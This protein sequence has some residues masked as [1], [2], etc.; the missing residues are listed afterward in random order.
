MATS[1][2]T[3]QAVRAALHY[4]P[5]TGVFRWLGTQGPKSKNGGVAG[6]ICGHT[7]YR[8]IRVNGVGCLAHRLAWLYM[9]GEWPKHLIDHMNHERADNRWA[10]LREVT[11]RANVE[12]KRLSSWNADCG[13]L[14]VSTS[15]DGYKGAMP[16]KAA[17]THNG[18]HIFIGRFATPQEAAAAYLGAKRMVHRG[19]IPPATLADTSM[20]P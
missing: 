12:N 16:Y 18:K 6:A 7:G 13:H 1:D 15:G 5:E 11:H 8:K 9:K 20:N 3:A 19:F 2:L 17:I 4:D 10:N 14:G